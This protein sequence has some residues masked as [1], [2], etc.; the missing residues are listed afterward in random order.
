MSD[1]T[2][3]LLDGR[4]RVIDLLGAGAMGSVYRGEHVKLGRVVA[5]KVLSDEL[6]NES[7]RLRFEREATAMAKLEH[8]NCASVLDVGVHA[9][10]PY[11]VMELVSGR[12]LKEV[13][14]NEEI[15]IARAVELTRQI[16]SGL[17]HAHEHGIIHR[18]IKPANIVVAKKA[19]VGDHVKLLDFGL[20]RF[21]NHSSNLTGAMVIG[22]PDYMAP[23]QVCGSELDHRVDLYACGIVLFEL[24]TGKRPFE[25]PD[26]VAMCMQQVN[27]EPPRLAARAPGRTFGALEAVVARALEKERDRRF[28][29]A[30]EFARALVEAAAKLDDTVPSPL[31]LDSTLPLP[32]SA[33]QVPT[34]S[35]PAHVPTPTSLAA[36]V[37]TPLPNSPDATFTPRAPTPLPV[38]P[39]RRSRLRLAL[40]AAAAAATLAIVL[41]AVTLSDQPA[42][43]PPVD[44]GV[45]GAVVLDAAPPPEAPAP[46]ADAVSDLLARATGLAASGRRQAAIDLLLDAR[47]TYPR[48]ARIPYE[49][50]KLYFEK[51]WWADGL[52]Q[53]RAAI[54]LDPAYRED[55]ELIKHVLKGFN[56]TAHY[57]GM[58]AR[59]LREDIGAAAKPFIAETANGHPNPIVRKRAA[60]EL[61]RYR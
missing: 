27:V 14:E 54:A 25:A 1:L 29:T 15:P 20:A 59:F 9:D 55:A 24:L 58:L 31:Q 4:Y 11:V 57:D 56:T 6:P 32:P 3:Q 42:A 60:R 52:K 22:T 17:A 35:M 37:P 36:H 19:G 47:K 18:D 51:L 39:A 7:S 28:A 45:A 61:R 34:T 5:V 50:S 49:A 30:E 33:A 48:D 13:I 26:A 21:R 46:S 12:N 44:A 10:R 53:A 23:E 16:L 8:P 43:Q 41:V 38:P 40:V 2:G